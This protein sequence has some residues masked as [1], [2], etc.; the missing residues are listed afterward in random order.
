MI[1]L[2][3]K[4][5]YIFDSIVFGLAANKGA[6]AIASS[7]LRILLKD[8]NLS[9]LKASCACN[10]EEGIIA[11]DGK[12]IFLWNGKELKVYD[13]WEHTKAMASKEEL[14]LC[15]WNY[16]KA[17]SWDLK[18]LWSLK[19]EGPGLATKVKGYWYVPGKKGLYVIK[20]G[21]IINVVK[22]DSPFK[23]VACKKGLALASSEGVTLLSLEN[24][25]AP[26]PLSFLEVEDVLFDVALSEDCN[27]LVMATSKGLKLF[28]EEFLELPTEEAVTATSF[29]EELY[30]S[31]GEFERSTVLNVEVLKLKADEL[32]T[33]DW[34]KSKKGKLIVVRNNCVESH[35]LDYVLD[36]DENPLTLAGEGVIFNGKRYDVGLVTS[37]AT[38]GKGFLACSDWS[39]TYYNEEEVWSIASEHPKASFM[40]GYFLIAAKD[41]LMLIKDGRIIKERKILMG[42]PL[43]IS[44]AKDKALVSFTR[45]S[46]VVDSELRPAWAL[47]E[48][49]FHSSF[50]G[51]A[52][53]IVDK[54]AK[55]FPL[56][57]PLPL[58]L[59]EASSGALAEEIY[60]VKNG[61]LI[62][63]EKPELERKELAPIV[64]V[65]GFGDSVKGIARGC[66]LAIATPSK[67]YIINESV[68]ELEGFNDVYYYSNRFIFVNEE[69]AL[70]VDCE[71]G[72]KIEIETGFGIGK[73]VVAN[74]KGIL[75]C[76]DS[77]CVLH[78]WEGKAIE[79]ISRSVVGKPLALRE[80]FIIPTRFGIVTTSGKELP[81]RDPLSVGL[82]SDE[83]LVG[84]ED[85]IFILTKDLK[86]VKEINSFNR[87]IAL[88]CGA[89]VEERGRVVVGKEYWFPAISSA[90]ID[91]GLLYIG[92]KNGLVY[93]VNID[94]KA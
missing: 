7:K 78:T 21:R 50:D 83:I 31:Y 79:A 92:T 73:W 85:A 14:L 22:V 47:E 29:G 74:E 89:L 28:S 58:D 75:T 33:A 68:K 67:S 4:R 5:S 63:I 23:A 91:R 12:R 48:S 40:N 84:G 76:G 39:C 88:S 37:V 57:D 8:K 41:K 69:K 54:R 59:G 64:D 3:A 9:I 77:G 18:E 24:P 90:L 26:E 56:G 72:L 42:E 71:S 15:Q 13:L 1:G 36:V 17:F 49:S 34:I 35:C 30:F 61:R 27:Y 70:M 81:L 16:C 51:E 93:T 52:V 10:W 6:L 55:L 82:C 44:V 80:D 46:V 60:L 11:S 43:N 32:G 86:F 53:L 62:R 65:M 66:G 2:K 45:G 20:D 87:V 19:I 38:D 94:R 25:E